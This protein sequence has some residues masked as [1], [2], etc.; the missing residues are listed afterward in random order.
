MGARKSSDLGDASLNRFGILN[1]DKQQS[2]LHA[3]LW[4]SGL[5]STKSILLHSLPQTTIDGVP[6]AIPQYVQTPQLLAL[7][8]LPKV[9][10]VLP[11]DKRHQNG[12]SDQTPPYLTPAKLCMLLEGFGFYYQRII[13]SVGLGPKHQRKPAPLIGWQILGCDLLHALL[14]LQNQLK[15]LNVLVLSPPAG[16]GEGGNPNSSDPQI[17]QDCIPPK[18]QFLSH[19]VTRGSTMSIAPG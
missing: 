15:C 2:N 5:W 7:E 16:T 4:P 17:T 13:S 10:T 12:K 19:L 3:P 8:N 1:S 14:Q 6:L 18:H 11:K 9:L